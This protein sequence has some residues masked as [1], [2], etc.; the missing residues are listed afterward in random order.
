MS[1]KQSATDDSKQKR[2]NIQTKRDPGFDSDDERVQKKA[3]TDPA[4]VVETIGAPPVG[5]TGTSIVG[6]GVETIGA[7]PMDRASS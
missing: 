2:P 5:S 3:K 1:T 6:G 7:P 4:P